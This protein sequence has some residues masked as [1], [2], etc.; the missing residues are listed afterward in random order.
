MPSQNLRS[1]PNPKI[2]TALGEAW[3]RLDRSWKFALG[4]YLVARALLTAWSLVILFLFPFVLENLT[5]FGA[6]VLAVLN[7]WTGDR[8]VY[9][10]QLDNTV[11]T[12]HVGVPGQV[13]DNQTGSVWA[14]QNGHG[15]SGS[16]TGHTLAPATF[17]V[18]EVF[19]YR[20]VTPDPNPVLGIWERFDA[21]WY[22]AIA[23][24][25]YGALSGDVHF[26][27]LYPVL[28]HLLGDSLG[29]A[30][31]ISNLALIAAL[32]FLY[33]LA[34]DLFGE[35]TAR[36]TTVYLLLFPTA[37]FF[38]SAYTEPLFLLTALLA[39]RAMGKR[40]WLWAGFWTFCGILI[41]LQ[42]VALVL[43]LVY[44]LWSARPLDKRVARLV[45]LV[46]PGIAALSYLGLRALGGDAAIVPITETSLSAR[47][48]FP[49]DNLLYAFQTLASG[50][51]LIADVL[52]LLITILFVGVLAAGWRR[53]P[54]LLTLYTVA[55]L[56]VLTIRLVDTQPLNSMSRY[57][58][59]LFPLFMLLGLWGQNRWVQRLVIYSSFALG[60]FLSA[61]FFLWGWVA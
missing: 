19:P 56:V 17:T 32:A 23:Q 6:P 41:R 48:A 8:Y 61:Q 57:V 44:A 27:P 39:L 20:G 36:R 24:H 55:S 10:R 40:S 42:G 50:K 14:L 31:L 37:F 1:R 7:V 21:Y 22:L 18:D 26:P 2:I 13:V 59:S 33:Q 45:A 16:Y 46:L 28:I 29:G 38:M 58:L 49:W 51:F 12:F 60:L 25:G 43:P 11:L 34:R 4:A 52:N 15:L 3:A 35:P 47:L 53:L 30:L 9:S 54:P 5:L